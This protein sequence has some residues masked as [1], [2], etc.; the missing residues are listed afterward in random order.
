MKFSEFPETHFSV[1]VY[2]YELQCGSL[3]S[4][5]FVQTFALN[6]DSDWAYSPRCS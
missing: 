6:F 3:L 5:L 2:G 4:K 1:S